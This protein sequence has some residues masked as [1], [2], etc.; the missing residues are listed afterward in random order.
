MKN[1][2]KNQSTQTYKTNDLALC[3]AL[4]VCGYPI[5][6]ID[7][8]NPSRAIFCIP[9]NEYLDDIVRL[10]LTHELR[11]DPLAYFNAIKEIKTRLY[12]GD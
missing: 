7:R 10:F 4:Y 2:Q 5:E 9:R 3:A 6:E 1:N 8:E 12:N 11:V